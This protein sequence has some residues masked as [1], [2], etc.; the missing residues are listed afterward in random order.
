MKLYLFWITVFS[1]PKTVPYWSGVWR[2]CLYPNAV[3][4]SNE[5]IILCSLPVIKLSE[6]VFHVYPS[7]GSGT[8]TWSP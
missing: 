1:Q 4:Q 7:P 2:V 8:E 3:D 5:P 6:I